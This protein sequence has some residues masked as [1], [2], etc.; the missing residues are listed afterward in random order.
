MRG[1]DTR[2]TA[3]HPSLI[4]VHCGKT[5]RKG[6]GGAA[7]KGRACQA[8]FNSWLPDKSELV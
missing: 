2:A 5:L 7:C 1:S 3:A 4:R 8:G 6:T